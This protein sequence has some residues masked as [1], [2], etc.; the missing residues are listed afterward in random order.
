MA[1]DM[2]CLSGPPALSCPAPPRLVLF[3]LGLVVIILAEIVDDGEPRARTHARPVLHRQLV[4]RLQ[5]AHRPRAEAG[6]AAGAAQS[7]FS[8]GLRC[9]T[10]ALVGEDGCHGL[11]LDVSLGMVLVASSLVGDGTH[12]VNPPMTSAN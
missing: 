5:S 8:A 2:R 3:R 7:L 9:R 12:A 4:A 6:P 1:S 11:S 10:D